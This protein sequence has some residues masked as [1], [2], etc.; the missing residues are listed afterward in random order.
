MKPSLHTRRHLASETGPGEQ[1]GGE[2]EGGATLREL[3][4][5]EET[6][7]RLLEESTE[8]SEK[9]EAERLRSRRFEEVI[10]RGSSGG[11]TDVGAAAAQA[12]KPFLRPFP[13]S[14]ESLPSPSLSSLFPPSS[15][16][17]SCTC[18]HPD[19]FSLRGN[20]LPLPL[21]AMTTFSPPSLGPRRCATGRPEARPFQ[22]SC[23][24]PV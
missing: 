12:S 4:A 7:A 16:P 2:A 1:H 14:L 11:S 17:Y 9:L 15:S 21:C 3:R 20:P 24:L 8:L 19:P 22:A 23:L 18:A 10:S 13:A 5:A 6:I